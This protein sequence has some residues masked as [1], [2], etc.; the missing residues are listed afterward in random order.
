MT[1]V[2]AL[3]DYLRGTYWAVPSAM[4]V[5]AVLLSIGMIQLDQAA[6]SKLLDPLSWIYTGGPE[7]ARA[8]LST[9]AASMIT[10]AGVTFSIT[11]VALTL[12]SQQFGPRVLRNFLRDVGNQVVLGTFVSTFLYCLLVLRTVRGSDDAEFVPHLAVTVGVTLA[13]LSLGVLIFFIHHVAT[14]I[15]ASRIIANV[16]GDLEGAVDRLFP[17][18][19]GHD[20][21]R[22]AGRD[23]SAE[24]RMTAHGTRVVNAKTTGYVQ[25]IDVDELM[26]VACEHALVARV[27]ARPGSFV[28]RGG[29]LLTIASGSGQA[30][31][32]DQSFH[33]MFIIGTDRT[34]TQDVTF[35]IDQLV[36]LAVRA[37]SPGIND[38]GTARLCIDR[39][40]QALCHL[41]GRQMLSPERYDD[42][43]RL[44]VIASPLTFPDVLE[45]AF[46][47]IARYGRSSASITCRLLE[48]VRHIGCCVTRDGDRLALLREATVLAGGARDAPLSD[49]D[50]ELIA[51]CHRVTLD[52]LHAQRGD[53]LAASRAVVDDQ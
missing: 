5:A 9:I 29:V 15:Q 43:G 8:V 36:E 38:P 39:L 52:V 45:S 19:I 51:Q 7:G 47:E 24:T 49:H 33:D 32:P 40:E 30:H 1:R 21:A 41:A 50:R 53:E 14:S 23:A 37:L 20:A 31:P 27:H 44:R 25:A 26:S 34:G 10:V 48:A 6:T 18:S 3:W 4:S 22:A 12:A 35:F 2:R 16:A 13:M 11:I 46:D 28:R 42:G 17:H